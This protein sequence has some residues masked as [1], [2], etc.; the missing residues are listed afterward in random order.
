MAAED[1]YR[2]KNWNNEIETEFESQLKRSR[3]AFN[4]AQYLRIQASYLLASPDSKI[5]RVGLRLMQRLIKDF[6]NEEL[7]TTFGHEQ[8]GDYF[9]KNNDFRMAEKHFRV[10]TDLYRN[11][12]SRSGTTTMADL[13][14]AETILSE[15]NPD[16]INEAYNLCKDFPTSELSFNNEIFYYADLFARVCDK[17]N[18]KDEAK[19]YAKRAIEISKI[20]EPQLSRHKTIGLVKATDEQLRIL[21]EILDK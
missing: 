4:K 9:L 13:K 11:K 5:Q 2:N 7:S 12:N 19:H 6:P 15:N 16:K 10:V 3:G 18:R 8:L 14:L 17:I 1:W 21:E 20:T